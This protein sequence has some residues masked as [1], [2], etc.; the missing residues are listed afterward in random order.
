M[1]DKI[2]SLVPH[3]VAVIVF[4]IFSSAYFSPLF[5]GYELRQGDVKQLRGMTKELED[6]KRVS[7]EQALWT[8]SMFGGMPTY[9]ITLQYPSNKLFIVEKV[10]KLGLPKA[11]GI[12]FTAML[13][14]Y[15]FA[16]CLRINPWIGIIGALAFGF[17]TINILYLGA[18]HITKVNAI[19][20]MA[21]ALGGLL[22]AF[23][24]KWLLGSGVFALFFALN[25]NANHLQMTYYLLFLLGAVAIGET[26]RLI[27]QKKGKELTR[28]LPALLVAS[29][30]APLPSIGNILSTQE[31]SKYTTR[32]ETDLTIEPDGKK[33]EI[34]KQS[35]LATDYIL[36]YNY[37]PGEI[38]S[39]IAPKAKGEKDEY[40]GNNEDA[41]ANIDYTYSEQVSKMNQYWGGQKM[42]GGAFYFGVIMFVLFIL[43]LVFLKDFI[44]WPFLVLSFLVVLLASNNPGGLNDFFIHKFPLYNKFRDSKMILVLLQVMIPAMAIL[45]LDRFIKKQEIWGEKKHW[46]IAGGAFA[47]FLLI[48]YVS[49]TIYGSFIR[50]DESRQFSEYLKSAKDP[51]QTMMIT[52]LKQSLIDVRIGMFKE[53]VGRAIGLTLLIMAI[54]FAMVSTKI[55]RYAFVVFIGI[56]V[57]WDNMSVAKR[58]LSNEEENGMYNSYDEKSIASLPY[59]PNVSDLSILSREQNQTKNLELTKQKIENEMLASEQFASADA[60][61]VN[62]LAAFGSLNLNSNYRVFNFGNPFNETGT[63]YFHK[64][65]GGYHGAKLK[66]YQEIIDFYITNEL[67]QANQAISKAKNQQLQKYAGLIDTTTGQ[68]LLTKE[69]AQSVFDTLQVDAVDMSEAPVLNMLNAKYLILNPQQQ[70]VKNN[71]AYGNAWFVGKFKTVKSSNDE[72]KSLGEVNLRENVV[73]NSAEFSKLVSNRIGKDRLSTIY[74]TNYSPNEITY[75]S[76]NSS[77][78]AVVFSEIYYPEG[79]NCYVDGKKNDQIFRAN[80]ILRGAIIP[81]GSHVIEWKFEPETFRKSNSIALIGSIL[82]YLLF[83]GSIGW[84]LK[85]ARNEKTEEEGKKD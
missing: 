75:N 33:K 66:R 53:D 22:L 55:N 15:I 26:V 60:G 45:F 72:M 73:V 63:S 80:Y 76:K 20:Y 43:G 3:F 36:E 77:T 67:Q 37:G 62:Q 52:G 7:G 48:F 25:L 51:Q 57:T 46:L 70:A 29:I 38:L 74:M 31:Y 64:S 30:I 59:V 13:G 21:P 5:N 69:S 19:A 9:Q 56:I 18:G 82:L 71:S 79:W 23:R 83:F 40:I 41:M 42:S 81:E 65:I 6:F 84:S 47:L 50:S 8:N 34:S 17:S 16:L 14:F 2:K 28:I 11:V 4:V 49:P 12:L 44:K 78:G 54:L 58:Y 85:T 35:G 27:L 10:I 68:P 24:G 39:V 32:G 61:S 1:K